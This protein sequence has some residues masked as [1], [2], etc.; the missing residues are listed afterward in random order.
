MAELDFAII[1]DHAR[2]EGGV[3]HIMAGA[4]DT[5]YAP[6]VPVG[7]NL[8]LAMRIL[9]TQNECG[10]PHRFDVIIQDADGE[11]L[12]AVNGTTTPEWP[13]GHPVH[14]SVGSLAALNMGIL[15]PRYG[16]YEAIIMVN[17]EQR[18]SLPLRVE[19]VPEG[20]AGG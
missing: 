15:F 13:D 17:D 10:R 16:F 7:H 12:A 3:V 19:S 9:F 2:V 11:R 20:G 1:A 18:K 8:S 6:Q 4:I 5:I 14:W